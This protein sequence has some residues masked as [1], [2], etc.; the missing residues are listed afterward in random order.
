[1]ATWPVGPPTSDKSTTGTG[2][3]SDFPLEPDPSVTSSV[4][5][6]ANVTPPRYRDRLLWAWPPC[7]VVAMAAAGTVCGPY[8]TALITA[9]L[10]PALVLFLGDE[11]MGRRLQIGVAALALALIATLIAAHLASLGPSSMPAG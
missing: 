2:D 1:M 5:H 8:G 10:V 4:V 7:V 11:V 6:R 9:V 3:A